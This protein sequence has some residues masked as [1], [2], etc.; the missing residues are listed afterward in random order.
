MKPKKGL[1]GRVGEE[2]V[3]LGRKLSAAYLFL[4]DITA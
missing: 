4:V 3:G 1:L 2:A